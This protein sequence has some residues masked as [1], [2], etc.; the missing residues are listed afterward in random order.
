ME[1]SQ[2]VAAT[3]TF[4]SAEK[5]VSENIAAVYLFGS[6]A[7]G[8]MKQASDIDL[9]VLYETSPPSTLQG[10]GQRL[11]GEIE[12]LLGIDVDLIVLN[13]ADCELVHEVLLGGYLLVERNSLARITFE[14]RKRSEYFDMIR[15]LQRYRQIP[16]VKDETSAELEAS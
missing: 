16:Y 1:L 14:V 7:S 9:A 4:F 12:D 6:Y 2:R 10:S 3:K 8:Q 15:H 13:K 5:M 11:A